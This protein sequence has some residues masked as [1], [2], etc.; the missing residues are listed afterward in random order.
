[1]ENEKQ[2]QEL[3]ANAAS[4]EENKK[5]EPIFD[6]NL[7]ESSLN[8]AIKNVAIEKK[9]V[10][11]AIREKVSKK[12][13][14]TNILKREMGLRSGRQSR[15]HTRSHDYLATSVSDRALHIVLNHITSEIYKDGADICPRI[16]MGI[17]AFG[18][19]CKMNVFERLK[20]AQDKIRNARGED[21][22]K[23]PKWILIS[24]DTSMIMDRNLLSRLEELKP[25]TY[26]AGA[27]GF[28]RIR[29]SGKWYEIPDPGEQKY[30]RGCY[31]QAN[32]ENKNWD[33]IVGNK[34]KEMTRDQILIVHG[35]FIALRG[36]LFMSIDFT[37]LVDTVE[38]G[39]YHYMAE[40]SMECCRRK[41]AVAQLKTIA[42]QF[43]NIN[44]V[45][46]TLEFQHDQAFFASKWQG[47]LPN[48]IP[49]LI[50]G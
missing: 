49:S 38:G 33:F 44:D 41:V 10:Y 25:T 42:A 19:K 22:L 16:L 8:T 14:E 40:I 21:P 17:P 15:Y 30:L 34:F 12:R 28:Q 2:D 39:F 24:N 46:E 35:P 20:L 18:N 9:K 31:I 5:E 48:K 50:E 27:Y 36:E 1:M 32:T 11:K 6:D 37:P 43:E 13:K 7:I 26:A 29:A 45:K 23:A 4:A 3:L 47:F